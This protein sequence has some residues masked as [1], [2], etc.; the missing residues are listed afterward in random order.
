[1]R[2][3]DQVAVVTGGS[4]GIGRAIVQALAADG[5]KVAFIY[6]GSQQAAEGLAREVQQAGGAAQALQPI[7]YVSAS[8]CPC[9]SYQLIP[10]SDEVIR[11]K[12]V[13]LPDDLVHLASHHLH[14][15]PRKI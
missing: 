6:R 14:S 11:R 10:S 12:H 2:L 1:M 13:E 3:K 9:L 7:G 4:R 5:A 15:H 8:G